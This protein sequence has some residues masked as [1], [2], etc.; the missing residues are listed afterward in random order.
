VAGGRGKD[1][2]EGMGG[3]GRKRGEDVPTVER[4]GLH[5]VEER[6]GENEDK[7]RQTD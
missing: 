6:R 3:I 2:K 5:T 1:D 7:G 4:G